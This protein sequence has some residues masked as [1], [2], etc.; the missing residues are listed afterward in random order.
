MMILIFIIS[1]AVLLLCIMK[2]K[3]NP[4]VALL[5]VAALTG[6]ATGMHLPLRHWKMAVRYLVSVL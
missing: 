3:L 2:F 6:L 5:V 1:I 4:F